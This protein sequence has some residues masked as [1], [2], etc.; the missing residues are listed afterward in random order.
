MAELKQKG[1]LYTRTHMH[2]IAFKS[3]DST[4]RVYSYFIFVL[5]VLWIPMENVI[6]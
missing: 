3:A 5:I 2:I 1:I 4:D 6:I